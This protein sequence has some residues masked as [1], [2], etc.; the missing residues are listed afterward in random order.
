MSKQLER[1]VGAVQQQPDLN[2]LTRVDQALLGLPAD[3][4]VWLS[5]C[6]YGL[7]RNG[8]AVAQPVSDA[9]VQTSIRVSTARRLAMPS[10]WPS[11]R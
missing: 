10:D 6:L 2:V 8:G 9:P 4:L 1:P 11:V 7:A 5:G 3:Q